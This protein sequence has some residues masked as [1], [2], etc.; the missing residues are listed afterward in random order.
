MEIINKPE[1][2]QYFINQYHI[3]DF[4]T[5][6]NLRFL[7]FHYQQGEK[8]INQMEKTIYLQFITYGTISV[9]ALHADGHQYIL[10]NSKNFTIL[11]DVEF[12]THRSSPFF[13]EAVDDVYTIALPLR[14]YE[15][16]LQNDLLFLHTLLA[17]LAQKIDTTS[18]EQAHSMSLE[19]KLIYH[20]QHISQYNTINHVEETAKI[21][22]C[23]R[24]QLQRILKKLINENVLIKSGKGNYQLLQK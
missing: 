10:A 17:S 20:L 1:L 7:L 11:G 21:L 9:Y 18:K 2:L 12:V 3:T 24:R 8:I 6:S 14:D 19:Q 15:A 5:T 23:S 16:Q 22:H 4:F 13:V